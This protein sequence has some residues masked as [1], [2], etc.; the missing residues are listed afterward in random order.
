MTIS[1]LFFAA[2]TV[3]WLLAGCWWAAPFTALMALYCADFGNK[4]K[5]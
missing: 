3:G 5:E 2:A 4:D 1:A